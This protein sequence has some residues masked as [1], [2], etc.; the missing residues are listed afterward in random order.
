MTAIYIGLLIWS[1]V[2]LISSYSA[3]VNGSTWGAWITGICLWV[4][5]AILLYMTFFYK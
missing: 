3:M 5:F 4:L 1:A 2:F